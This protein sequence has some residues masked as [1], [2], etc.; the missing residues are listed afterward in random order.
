MEQLHNVTIS[1]K[2]VGF[3]SLG[4]SAMGIPIATFDMVIKA[5]V[6][7]DILIYPE[8]LYTTITCIGEK[9]V[10]AIQELPDSAEITAKGWGRWIAPSGVTLEGEPEDD[11][12]YFPCD[13]SVIAVSVTLGHEPI[14]TSRKFILIM[15][16]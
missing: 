13:P 2:F 10:A 14:N 8:Y 1:G 9:A 12:D 7:G 15:A 3:F 4:S 5:W 11:H 6:E 16:S